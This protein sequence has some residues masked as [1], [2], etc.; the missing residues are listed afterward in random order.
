M[1]TLTLPFQHALFYVHYMIV[2]KAM[3]DLNFLMYLYQILFIFAS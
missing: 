3:Y 2:L 1:K